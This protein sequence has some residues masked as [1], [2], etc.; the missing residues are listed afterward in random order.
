M[1]S[2]SNRVGIKKEEPIYIYILRLVDGTHYTGITNDLERR[3]QEHQRGESKSTKF[4]LPIQSIFVTKVGDRLRAREVE[5]QIKRR[6]A[7]RWLNDLRFK[8]TKY[9]FNKYAYVTDLEDDI[10]Y[11]DIE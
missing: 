4:K 2:S 10:C 6:G 9:D 11:M 5:V 8:N 1:E 7:K 3:M